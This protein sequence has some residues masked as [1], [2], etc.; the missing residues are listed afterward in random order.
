MFTV[1]QYH[2]HCALSIRSFSTIFFSNKTTL[3][4]NRRI[5]INLVHNTSLSVYR[6]H[7]VKTQSRKNE[8][9]SFDKQTNEQNK[10]KM[11]NQIVVTINQMNLS[12]VQIT[13]D[14]NVRPKKNM[15][16]TIK[17]CRWMNN[18]QQGKRNVKMKLNHFQNRNTKIRCLFC[19]HAPKIEEWMVRV[20]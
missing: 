14:Q 18:I 19:T 2:T 8:L 16:K 6:S 12:I 13:S 1:R 20:S 15:L 9:I 3:M 4:K 17:L 10:K 7:A 11:N 5:K